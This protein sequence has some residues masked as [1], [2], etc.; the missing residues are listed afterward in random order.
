MYFVKGATLDKIFPLKIV[1]SYG[2][3]VRLKRMTQLPKIEQG[4]MRPMT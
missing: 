2:I 1:S 3:G 4:V